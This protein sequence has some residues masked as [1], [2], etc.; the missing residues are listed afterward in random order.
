MDWID[1][2]AVLGINSDA[3]LAKVGKGW[4]RAARGH[5]GEKRNRKRK[6]RK[7]NRQAFRNRAVRIRR[8]EL[9]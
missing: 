1:W 6:V 7:L 8:G 5:P 9:W 2:D 3:Q 4:S